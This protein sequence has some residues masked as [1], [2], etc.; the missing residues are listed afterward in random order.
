MLNKEK[1]SSEVEK[2]L[3]TLHKAFSGLTFL[4]ADNRWH[5]RHKHAT[6]NLE[7]S[8]QI[9]I[10]ADSWFHF[11]LA[12]A[13]YA[14]A[15]K[16]GSVCAVVNA[17]NSIGN[18]YGDELNI[19][20]PTDFLSLKTQLGE[21]RESVL[22]K[23]RGFFKFWFET[24]IGGISE[25]FLDA[26][27][28]VKIKGDRKGEAVKSLDPYSGPY[29]PIELQAVI[30][31]TNNAF[32]EDS[33][34]I[35]DYVL[36]MF[37]A[38]RGSRTNQ[39]KDLRMMDFSLNKNGATANIPR[40]KQKG[41][42]FR[43]AFKAFNISEDLYRLLSL[44][45]HESL[46]EIFKYLSDADKHLIEQVTDDLLPVFGNW[47]LF[48]RDLRSIVESKKVTEEHHMGEN[49]LSERLTRVGEIINVYSERTGEVINLTSRRFRRTIGTDIAREGGG[50]GVIASALDHTDYQNAGVYVATSADMATRL[51]HKIGKLLAPLA[52]AFAG[53]LVRDESEAV[54]GGD[55]GSRIRT[56]TGSDNVG[57]CG[58]FSF[59]GSRAPIACYTCAK[60]QPWVDAPHEEIL[61]DL[62]EERKEILDV[63]GDQT[64]ASQLD[65]SILAVEDVIRRCELKRIEITEVD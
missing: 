26:I 64:I 17:L 33:L 54:R 16:A 7:G 40:G 47:R 13:R 41:V 36:T 61:V 65:R 27:Y 35:R 48:A 55:P 43:E 12:L 29:T 37:F 22:G 18:A 53:V 52:Q 23:L 46:E 4:P 31:G 50:V 3:N 8:V 58:N 34:Q 28:Q 1:T 6:V 9:I 15:N 24:G 51:D 30:D 39:I 45:K 42:G 19:L 25:E 2:L 49:A 20:N 11:K 44:L 14:Q 32:L 59:C 10:P 62:Y 38:Q 60:F 56:N 57:S 5:L 21:T 63:T